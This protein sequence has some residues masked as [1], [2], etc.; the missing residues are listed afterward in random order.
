MKIT[1][2]S[3]PEIEA[4]SISIDV[5]STDGVRAGTSTGGDIEVA[6]EGDYSFRVSHLDQAGSLEYAQVS[7]PVALAVGV[8]VDLPDMGLSLTCA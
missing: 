8:S 2:A 3:T 5:F 4:H 7:E 1:F 6:A